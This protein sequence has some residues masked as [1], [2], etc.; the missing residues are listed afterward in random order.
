[1]DIFKSV[2]QSDE[3]N[4]KSQDFM[5]SPGSPRKER[6][7]F[8]E[9]AFES[10]INFNYETSPLPLHINRS[11]AISP[12]IPIFGRNRDASPLFNKLNDN[13]KFSPYVDQRELKIPVQYKKIKKKKSFNTLKREK[14]INPFKNEFKNEKEVPF[15]AAVSENQMSL[16]EN[17]NRV[18]YTKHEQKVF[19]PVEPAKKETKITCNCKNSKCL[20]LYCD[21]LRA[22]GYCNPSCNCS[23]CENYKE[24]KKRKLK[25]KELER[26]NPLIFEPIV[27]NKAEGKD[28]MIHHRGCSCKK[29]GCLKNYCECQ[30]FGVLCGFHCKCIGC[31]NCVDQT[32]YNTKKQYRFESI[33]VRTILK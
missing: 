15:F 30:Q 1:M 20:K 3:M 27:L 29:N 6:K 18:S 17:T 16:L 28:H 8:R 24:S 19:D 22:N 10:E 2:N 9:L 31:Q 12:V 21:C 33:A 13:R 4:N 23:N 25:V 32:N 14:R 26:K 11:I 5:F 7:H